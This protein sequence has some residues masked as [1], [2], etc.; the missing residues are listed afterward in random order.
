MKE[1][2]AKQA[3]YITFELMV[4]DSKEIFSI[5]DDHDQKL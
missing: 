1:K 4:I 3:E 2:Y 5:I